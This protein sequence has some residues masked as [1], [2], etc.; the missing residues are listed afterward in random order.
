MAGLGRVEGGGQGGGGGSGGGD[1]KVSLEHHTL[2]H[3]LNIISDV[4][5]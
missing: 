2:I 1:I 3:V 4:Q 5:G